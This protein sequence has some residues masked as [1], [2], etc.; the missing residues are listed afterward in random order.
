MVSDRS[1]VGLLGRSREIRVLEELAAAVQTGQGHAL[2]IRGEAGM[3][4]SAL[5]RQLVRAK[6]QLRTLRALG[7]ESEMELPFGGLHQLCDPLLDLLPK[8]P[9]PQ[10]DA[11]GTVFGS[12]QG[13]PPDRLLVGLAALSLLCEA[14]EGKPLLCVVDDGHWLDHAS[15]QALAFVGRRLLADPVGLVISTREVDVEFS[16]L[17]ELVLG[18]LPAADAMALLRSLP[19]APLDGQV[20]DRIVAEAHGNPLALLEWRR[21]LTPAEAVGGKGLSGGRRLS[22]RLEESFR[23]RLADLPAA[24]QRFALVAAAEPMGDASLVWRAAGRLGVGDD[25]ALPAIDEGL[26]EVGAAIRFTHPLMRSAAYWLLSSKE[27]QRAH[28]A[29]GDTIDAGSDPDLRVWHRA[30]ATSAP[31]E[32]IAQELER[33]AGRARARGG[34]AAVA[35][36]LERSAIL[37]PDPSRRAERALAAAQAKAQMGEYP[38]ALD[39]LAIAEAGPLGEVDR[40]GIDVVRAQMAFA[41]NRGRNAPAL[42]LR[43]AERLELVNVALARASYLDAL[44]AAIHAGRLANPDADFHTVMQ[45]AA[46]LTP[47][48]AP[49]AEDLLLEG[50]TKNFTEGYRAAVPVLRRALAAFANEALADQEHRRVSLAYGTAHY[51][52][53][54]ALSETLGAR[55][56]SMVRDLGALSELAIALT[57]PIMT[58][59]FEGRLDAAA[60]LVEEVRAIAAATHS[61]LYPHGVMFY[62][63]VRGDERE[64]TAVMRAAVADGIPHGEDFVVSSSDWAAAVLNNGLGHYAEALAAAT[65]S[66]QDLW[67]PGF[68]KWAIVEL[69]E[70]ATRCGAREAAQEASRRLAEMAL[71]S[72]TDWALGIDSRSRALLAGDDQAEFLYR[73]AID[74]LERTRVRFELARAHLLYGEWLRR[75]NRRVDARHQLRT[76]DEMLT[77]MGANGFA[78]RA[79]R[80]LLATGET[81]RKR[82][83]ETTT[84]LTDQEACIARLVAEGLTNLEIAAQLFLSARTVEWHLRKVFTKL[85]LG[86]RQELRRLLRNTGM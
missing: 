53:D 19:G 69:I 62:L 20:R 28:R 47:P 55:C 75:Q 34:I 40:A 26:M 7:V 13:N 2:V 12:R 37:S 74:R 16:G 58:M 17:P 76:A 51:L 10:Q 3:G 11:L 21:A 82:R 73:D 23:H 30:L 25:A 50:L 32:G 33:S 48:D 6:P 4:K 31:E 79:R 8:L 54:D 15:A 64:F 44:H 70:A 22:G 29:L 86:S 60:V 59:V 61:S 80:E 49:G 24:T 72:G 18:G 1:D 46:K 45:A 5:M 27:R 65:R 84:E 67:Q 43:A 78:E 68:S 35:A 57:P 83:A 9:E 39:L 56:E 14:A 85:G 66:S 36:F 42:Y 41:S 81:V 77:A 52:W 71:V 38:A 63:A